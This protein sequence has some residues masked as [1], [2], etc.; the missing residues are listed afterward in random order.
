MD[1]SSV[2][3]TKENEDTR[4]RLAK[5][6]KVVEKFKKRCLL[7]NEVN[8]ELAN[9]NELLRSKISNFEKN[10]YR[11]KKKMSD[12]EGELNKSLGMYF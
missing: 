8:K 6:L 7:E 3:T 11:L 9:R 10:S 12:I 1:E 2:I 5:A 4:R